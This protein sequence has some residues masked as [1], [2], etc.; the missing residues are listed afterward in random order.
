MSPK[1]KVNKAEAQKTEKT[2]QYVAIAMVVI[3]VAL[4]AWPYVAKLFPKAETA[5][6]CVLL[7]MS[8]AKPRARRLSPLLRR[9]N[10]T[11]PR[12]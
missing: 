8:E 6:S 10:I 7:G 1:K 3:V 11:K 12:P 2:I 9:I 4:V 5:E